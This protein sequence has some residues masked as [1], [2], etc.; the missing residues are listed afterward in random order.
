VPEKT[1]ISPAPK[2][3]DTRAEEIRPAEK[4]DVES[5]TDAISFAP[6]LEV[7][8][9]AGVVDFELDETCV[10]SVFSAAESEEQVDQTIKDPSWYQSIMAIAIATAAYRAH[11]LSAREPDKSASRPRRSD[12]R[13][14]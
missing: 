6:E 9:S 7:L 1:T 3:I 13:V 5:A 10:D 2:S 14:N 4:G 12:S 11:S 8:T